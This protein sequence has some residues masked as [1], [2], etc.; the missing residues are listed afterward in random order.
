MEVKN[1]TDLVKMVNKSGRVLE[2]QFNGAHYKLPIDAVL[3]TTRAIA[4]HG[5]RATQNI[6]KDGSVVFNAE[7][8][9]FPPEQRNPL[10]YPAASEE[11]E[12]VRGEN[13]ALKEKVASLES[14]LSNL[15]TSARDISNENESLKEVNEALTAELNRV[16][17]AMTG[18]KSKGNPK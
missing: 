9:E 17:S 3:R 1:M 7:I 12:L 16:R 15:E 8:E 4:E 2:F 6:V 5:I 18:N 13:V 10:S 14:R 11:M